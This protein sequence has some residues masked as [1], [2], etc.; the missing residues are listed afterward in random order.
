METEIMIRLLNSR[1]G[2]MECRGCGY[3]HWAFL[4]GEAFAADDFGKANR[5]ARSVSG[6]AR[7]PH[8]KATQGHS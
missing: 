6:E 2:E 3:D 1:S 4:E 7:E 5:E 8:G